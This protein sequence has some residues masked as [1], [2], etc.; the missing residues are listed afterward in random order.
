M[1]YS[2][3]LLV[4]STFLTCF[5]QKNKD[6]DAILV[7]SKTAAFRHDCIPTGLK[8]LKKLAA[9]AN[10]QV[11]ATEDANAFTTEK[12]QQ[13]D[14]IVFF[15][16]TGNVLNNKQQSALEQYIQSGGGFVGIHSAADTEYEWPWYNK[17]VGAYFDGHPAIQSARLVVENQNHSSTKMLPKDWQRSDEWYNYKSIY[18]QINV[19]IRIDET[20]YKGGTNGKNHPMAWY[21]DFDGGR[22][23]YT[24]LGHTHESYEEELFQAHLLGGIRYAMGK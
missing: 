24:G 18:E 5:T 15:N 19:L 11:V 7:F 6:Q 12:L 23:F 10:I 20:S 14:A 13:F 8:A 17:L 4:L 2:L 1:K 21:H 22:S 3:L 16:T 9:Q